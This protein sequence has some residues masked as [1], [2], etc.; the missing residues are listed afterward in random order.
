M[1]A[2]AGTGSLVQEFSQIVASMLRGWHHQHKDPA[3]EVAGPGYFGAV[4]FWPIYTL[5]LESRD[6]KTVHLGTEAESDDMQRAL[7]ETSDA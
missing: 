3:F 2:R 1:Q 6:F 5:R 7:P 4:P